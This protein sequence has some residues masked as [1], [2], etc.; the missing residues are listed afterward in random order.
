MLC[1]CSGDTIKAAQ[2]TDM[3]TYSC[4]N[5]LDKSMKIPNSQSTLHYA[6]VDDHPSGSGN[7]I[8][9]GRLEVDD[10]DGGWVG[11]GFSPNGQMLGQAV[12]GIHGGSV[13]KYDLVGYQTPQQSS[14]QTIRDASINEVDGKTVMTF[15]KLLVEEGEVPIKTEGNNHFLHALGDGSELA[16]HG[17]HRTAFKINFGT[18]TAEDDVGNNHKR[19]EAIL[20]NK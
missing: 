16:Y 14:K 7:G 12:I 1:L 4:P 9:C 2:E 8:L 5:T 17:P 15:T 19:E 20:A 10:H 11:L 18:T 3:Y 13:L 6:I